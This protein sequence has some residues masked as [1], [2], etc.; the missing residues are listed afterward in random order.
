MP[1]DTRLWRAVCQH[2]REMEDRNLSRQYINQTRNTLRHWVEYLM[3]LGIAA[4]SKI[5]S[6]AIR[7]FLD[8][9][10][11]QSSAS[12]RK[13]WAHMKQFL[14]WAEHPLALKFEYRV[15]GRGRFKVDWLSPE[16]T[17]KVL[18]TEMTLREAVLV[19]GHFLQGARPVELHRL[20]VRDAREAIATGQIRFFGKCK[21][22][23][24]PL[25]KEYRE[26]LEQYLLMTDKPDSAPLLGIETLWAWK[27]IKKVS[28]RAGIPFT[29]YTGRRTF[30]R[31]LMLAGVRTEKISRLLGHSSVN[32]TILYLGLNELDLTEAMNS[33]E[34]PHLRTV[35]KLPV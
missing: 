13:H 3:P 25:K 11:D 15:M 28:A 4:T 35:V 26:V 16:Q 23:F 1:K 33:L 10:K 5:T 24:V 32:T 14:I 19:C 29:G 18:T 22:R 6:D 7:G 17:E 9:Y 8:K 12:Q 27:I 34:V 21:E 20:T 31:N 30:A 2:L